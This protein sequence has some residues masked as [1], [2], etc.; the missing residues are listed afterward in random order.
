VKSRLH[1]GVAAVPASHQHQASVTLAPTAASH[2]HQASVTLA[3][4]IE[5]VRPLLREAQLC[6]RELSSN[7]IP[8]AREELFIAWAD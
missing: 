2:Q 7:R 3:P 4:T 6:G 8:S 1:N 5:G